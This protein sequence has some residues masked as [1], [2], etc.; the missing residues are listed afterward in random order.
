M[1]GSG[2]RLLIAGLSGDTGKTI[3]TLAL[4]G[5]L[6]QRNL[7]AVPFKKGPDYID[8][9]WLGWAA[10]R[11][12][13]NLDS[14]MVPGERLTA[15]FATASS[16]ANI[17][18]IEGNRGVF[19]GMDVEGTHS[20]ATIAKL[21][22]APVVLVVNTTKTT[23]SV[24]ALVKGC[25]EFDKDL[26]VAGVI[27]NRIAGKRHE[28]IIREAIEK[29]CDIPVLGALPKLEGAGI[30]IP[31]RHLGLIPPTEIEESERYRDKLAE[32]G[33]DYLDIDRLLRIA[34]TA[35][36]FDAGSLG[37]G[38]IV[39]NDVTIGYFRDSV[40]T[41]YYPENLEALE[42]AGATLRPISSI[43]DTSLGDID[44]L[45]IGG[46]F[47]ET[48]LSKLMGNRRLM[49]AVK[50][51]A[52]NGMPIYA[53]CGG[54]IYLAGELSFD[55]AA[56]RM[57]GVFDVKLAMHRKPC[58][59]GYA[60]MIVDRPNPYF[61]EGTLLRGHEFHYTALTEP[62]GATCLSVKRGVGVGDG[63]DGLIYRNC[64]ATY[65]HIHAEGVPNWAQQL[66]YTASG[67]RQRKQQAASPASGG[68]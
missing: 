17:A 14:F 26:T 24:A 62:P 63:R 7:T 13:R 5:A 36:P 28:S 52:E 20:T 47:P 37:P 49:D 4:L 10:G 65:M 43:E 33:S 9:A 6:R 27:L 19:D 46:G 51:A 18:I 31:Q 38:R 57:A 23:R 48:Q 64:L 50:Q 60:E 15:R 58:G 55:G 41:F 54:L 25:L 59:H 67:F 66:V 61:D 45:Y 53:E 21:T 40:F 44:G 12:C 42:E 11:S 34:E 1:S 3:V 2:P 8:A 35:P 16:G 29:Y 32:I 22:A 30:S 68:R 39:T 56:H